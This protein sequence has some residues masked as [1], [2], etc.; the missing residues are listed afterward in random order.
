VLVAVGYE[1]GSFE[2]VW[3]EFLVKLIKS[4]EI[5]ITR[6]PH[7]IFHSKNEKFEGNQLIWLIL[8]KK[9]KYLRINYWKLSFV[10]HL[11]YTIILWHWTER[12]RH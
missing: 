12:K 11:E 8:L 7:A 6:K 10:T 5:V 4:M 3:G 2:A 1:G 9:T